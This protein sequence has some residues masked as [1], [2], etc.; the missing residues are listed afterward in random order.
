MMAEVLDRR[1]TDVRKEQVLPDLL[2][3]DGGKAQLN[4]ALAVLREL[5]LADLV[6]VVAWYRQI[7]SAREK[8]PA[9]AEE[10]SPFAFSSEPTA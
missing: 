9:G 7:V 10:R 8:K 1:F 2:V 4:Q 3:V 5:E 6:P